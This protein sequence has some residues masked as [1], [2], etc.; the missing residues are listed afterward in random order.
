MDDSA[1]IQ[2]AVIQWWDAGAGAQFLAAYVL[3]VHL[4]L[5]L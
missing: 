1:V 5:L 4:H 2:C 3:C